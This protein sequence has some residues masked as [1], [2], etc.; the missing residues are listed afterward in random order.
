MGS[1]TDNLAEIEGEDEVPKVRLGNASCAVP[2]T[3]ELS[4]L[5]ASETWCSGEL[6]FELILCFY[7]H[8]DY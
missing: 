7:N 3:S 1:I 8:L 4:N 2:F 5:V 6:G